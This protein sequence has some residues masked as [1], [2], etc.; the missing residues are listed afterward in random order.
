VTVVQGVGVFLIIAGAV[1]FVL[2][3]FLS[4]R[5]PNIARHI[6]LLNAN[7]LLNATVG[8]VLLIVGA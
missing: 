3:R 1:E 7:A 8:V 2:F 5:R 4:P 6:R